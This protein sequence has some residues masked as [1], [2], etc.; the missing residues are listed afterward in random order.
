MS[1]FK[2]NTKT[3]ARIF[4]LWFLIFANSLLAQDT[5]KKSFT[6]QSQLK[7]WISP[8]LIQAMKIEN[9]GKSHLKAK[10]NI[11]IEIGVGLSERLNNKFSINVGAGLGV[12]PESF[13][14]DFK[15]PTTSIFY[16]SS[17]ESNSLNTDY[18]AYYHFNYVFPLS[19]EYSIFQK[20]N[21]DF[22]VDAGIK[23]NNIVAHPFLTSYTDNY[24]IDTLKTGYDAFSLKTY[25][26]SK[27]NILS[28]TLK[29]GITK[30]TKKANTLNAAI[31]LN[32][33]PKKLAKGFYEYYNLGYES[34]GNVSLGINYVGLELS[35]GI[36]FRKTVNR[37][38][39]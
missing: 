4:L 37:N 1:N 24:T 10:P 25:S 30:Q 9:V 22:H 33:S 13:Y 38:R 29:F 31:V 5:V 6:Y 15:A 2:Y 16:N 12:I 14:Y 19:I 34:K 11:G 7:F 21:L 36:A 23:L 28:Y 18:K 35:Y 32:Y 17:Y 27:K 3:I 20:K 8:N 39:F 26:A